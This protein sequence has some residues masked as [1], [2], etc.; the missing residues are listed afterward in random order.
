MMIYLFTGLITSVIGSLPPGAVNLSVVYTTVN[1]GKKASTPILVA[2]SFGELIVAA[3]ALSFSSSI[4]SFLEQNIVPQLA[5]ASIL[6]IVG[7]TLLIKKSTSGYSDMNQ[8][9][10]K[11]IVKGIVFATFNPPVFVF[12]LFAF[13]FLFEN[14]SLIIGGNSEGYPF[15]VGIFIGKIITLLGYQSL[16]ANFKSESKKITRYINKGI[17]VIL[18]ILGS[19]QLL[20]LA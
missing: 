19:L 15:F 12:W 10:G 18:L 9:K 14:S 6:F 13:A 11:G 3:I 7:T 8:S 4:E 1:N 16:S 20:R 5:L 2:G 17:G